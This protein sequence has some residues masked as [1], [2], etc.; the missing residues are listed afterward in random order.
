MWALSKQENGCQI[1][2]D[3]VGCGLAVFDWL[4]KCQ[5]DVQGIVMCRNYAVMDI[6][7]L[8]TCRNNRAAVW[9]SL[10]EAL[11]PANGCEV[12]IPPNPRLIRDLTTMEY[13]VREGIL[14]M[15]PRQAF[16]EKMG[17]SPD[18]G[19]L[20][21]L[22]AVCDRNVDAKSKL[23]AVLENVDA[24]SKIAAVLGRVEILR[25]RKREKED[26]EIRELLKYATPEEREELTNM[27]GNNEGLRKQGR[28]AAKTGETAY[29]FEQELKDIIGKLDAGQKLIAN[30]LSKIGFLEASSVIPQQH[31]ADAHKQY[32][33]ALIKAG[34][35]TSYDSFLT[36]EY[37]R[38]LQALPAELQTNM[39]RGSGSN[40]TTRKGEIK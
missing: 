6:I 12:A 34:Y 29:E 30:V 39:I 15:L 24:K 31:L 1:R 25:K 10:R 2:I 36:D 33:Q 23:A 14:D 35:G 40:N 19:Q 20:Y 18:L 21:A 28:E 17:S 3:P 22:A 11:N 7:G 13:R 38:R 16:I 4:K 9:W 5:A 37:R 27:L 26:A 32:L 8:R